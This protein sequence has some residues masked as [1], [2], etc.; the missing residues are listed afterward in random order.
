MKLSTVDCCYDI[1]FHDS[2]LPTSSNFTTLRTRSNIIELP[3]RNLSSLARC[4]KTLA[5]SSQFQHPRKPETRP[6]SSKTAP[7]VDVNPDRRVVDAILLQT[8]V[9]TRRAQF[10]SALPCRLVSET[11]T[12]RTVMHAEFF[13]SP[14]SLLVGDTVLISALMRSATNRK[15]TVTRSDRP[16]G[17]S[18]NLVNENPFTRQKTTLVYALIAKIYRRTRRKLYGPRVLGTKRIEKRTERILP[19]NVFRAVCFLGRELFDNLVS[20]L[21]EHGRLYV[22]WCAEKYSRTTFVNNGS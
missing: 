16:T 9:H 5:D 12:Q 22:H 21:I 17:R 19:R 7:L 18:S 11:E 2:A 8:S 20:R 1:S 10:S 15:A 13:H 14:A 4:R 6:R 3:S